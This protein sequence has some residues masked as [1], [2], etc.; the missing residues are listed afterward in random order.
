MRWPVPW[1]L[2]LGKAWRGAWAALAAVLL[3]CS[4]AAAPAQCAAAQLAAPTIVLNDTGSAFREPVPGLEWTDRGGNMLLQQLLSGQGAF[5]PLQP[6]RIH[7]LGASGALWLHL[8]AARPAG[9]RMQWLAELPLPSL[10]AVTLYQQDAAGAWQAQAAGDRIAVASWPEPGRFPV[11]RLDV[12]A[13]QVRDLYFRVQ[14]NAHSNIP[15]R[16]VTVTDHAL[17][18]ELAYLGLGLALGGL[19]LL[20]AACLVQSWVFRDRAFFGY[21]AYA[22]TIALAMAAFTGAAGHLLWPHSGFLADVAQGGTGLLSA[23][24]AMLFVRDLSGA[25][26]RTPRLAAVARWTAFSVPLLLLAY[27]LVDRPAGTVLLGAYLALACTLNLA[28]A[29]R[30]WRRGDTVSLWILAAYVPLAV[31]VVLTL[32]RI[33]GM[34]PASW[35]NQ[36]GMVA[37]MAVQVP[38]LLVALGIHS[39][40]RHGATIRELALS[41]QDALTGLLAPHLFHDRLRQL[42]ARHQRNGESAAVLFI[43]LANYPKIKEQHGS[44]VAEQSL[45]RSVIKLR[46]LLREID[47]LSRIG[48]AR[49]GV[50]LER[51]GSRVTVN[52]RAARAVAAGMMPA[53]GQ[54]E[55]VLQFHVAAALL[56]EAGMEA[57]EL[58]AAL[59]ALLDS[60]AAGTRRPIRFLGAATT[61]PLS[62][63]ES[64]VA[65]TDIGS[66]PPTEGP[67]PA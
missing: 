48:E 21:A 28:I 11:F 41:S 55:V 14:H 27:C 16:I 8:R 52:D 66:L 57:P 45:L 2:A 67:A 4:F 13:G 39:R 25:A 1:P 54:P 9:S 32:M 37:A 42:V 64:G 58:A 15:L 30:A 31:A 18:M 12:P 26:I 43:D 60:M 51:T 63:R 50:I 62:A 29:W 65:D 5:G 22:S 23:A 20:I 10:D 61:V 38:L 6:D 3:C 33:F 24:A 56:D 49:F 34:A 53:K 7:A 59:A 19:L 46:R 47:T 40:E 44:A 17:R 36:Y 35:A